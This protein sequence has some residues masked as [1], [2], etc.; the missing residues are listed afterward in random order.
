MVKNRWS[1]YGNARIGF[2]YIKREHQPR[3]ANWILSKNGVVAYLVQFGW[4]CWKIRNT[5][6]WHVTRSKLRLPITWTNNEQFCKQ[7]R[8]LCFREYLPYSKSEGRKEA[9][10]IEHLLKK[11][12][13]TKELAWISYAKVFKVYICHKKILSLS[14]DYL[15][16]HLKDNI[17]LMVLPLSESFVVAITK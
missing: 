13:S 15:G 8:T 10:K 5:T 2:R 17:M 11:P 3:L 1:G 4:M 12:F 14:W 6:R 7:E 9:G 16:Y